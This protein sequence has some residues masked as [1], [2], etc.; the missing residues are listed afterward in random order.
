MKHQWSKAPGFTPCI[1]WHSECVSCYAPADTDTKTCEEY[2]RQRMEV[3][4]RTFSAFEE[5]AADCANKHKRAK[6]KYRTP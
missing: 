5:R 3:A 1:G 4:R 2:R 6:R